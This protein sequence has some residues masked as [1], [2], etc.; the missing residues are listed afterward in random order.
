ME[1]YDGWGKDTNYQVNHATI[2]HW[3]SVVFAVFK[4]ESELTRLGLTPLP[5]PIRLCGRGNRAIVTAVLTLLDLLCNLRETKSDAVPEGWGG[6]KAEGILLA[7]FASDGSIRFRQ[8]P[9]TGQLLAVLR[10]ITRELSPPV[11]AQRLLFDDAA[12]TVTLD[13]TPFQVRDPVPFRLLQALYNA[14]EGQVVS[15]QA[16]MKMLGMLNKNLSREFDKL[17]KGLGVIV[18]SNG[19]KGYWLQ[20]PAKL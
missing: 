10:R 13:G 4:V 20:L 18:K 1:T 8:M 6:T 7:P 9:D 11:Q 17:P 3:T 16:L 19:G 15:G 2:A 5:F 14:G 12:R